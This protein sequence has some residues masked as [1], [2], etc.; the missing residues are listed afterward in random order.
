[1]SHPLYHPDASPLNPRIWLVGTW[2]VGIFNQSFTPNR[3]TASIDVPDGFL[4]E[5]ASCQAPGDVI[6]IL[7]MLFDSYLWNSFVCNCLE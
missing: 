7:L 4:E 5:G 1:M 3:C 2:V 6:V